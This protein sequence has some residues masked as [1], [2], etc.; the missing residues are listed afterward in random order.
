[1]VAAL[2]SPAPAVVMRL[3]DC[4]GLVLAEEVRATTPLPP[5]T[6]SAMDGFAS[7]SPTSAPHLL[8]RR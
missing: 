1:M 2:I 8:E 5:F 6:N 7:A 3:A 4:L